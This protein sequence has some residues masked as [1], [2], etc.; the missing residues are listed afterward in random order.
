MHEGAGRSGATSASMCHVVGEGR[1]TA[2]PE[3]SGGW[4]EVSHFIFVSSNFGFDVR[5][6]ACA[7]VRLRNAPN[8]PSTPPHPDPCTG[9][10]GYGAAARAGR[11]AGRAACACVR[12]RT[13]RRPCVPAAGLEA[14]RLDP[15]R[16]R[17]GVRILTSPVP[18]A[19]V[20]RESTQ[21]PLALQIPTPLRS[22][23]YNHDYV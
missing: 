20:P 19:A 6:C 5:G 14:R 3:R 12:R 22:V 23:Q 9:Q 11:S 16:S 18:V 17:C 8:G 7:S 4:P 10:T 21:N 2:E 13:R 15:T 1:L